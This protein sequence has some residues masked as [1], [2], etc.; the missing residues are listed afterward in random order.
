MRR[1]GHLERHRGTFLG[2][3]GLVGLVAGFRFLAHRRGYLAMV[4][5]HLP[6]GPPEFPL[7]V[8]A[9][10]YDWGPEPEPR[11]LLCGEEPVAEDSTCRLRVETSDRATY[12]YTCHARC[13]ARAAHESLRPPSLPPL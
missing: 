8:V 10:R 11:C 12:V 2:L 5:E 6:P 4:V 1:I 9:E 13:V 7:E 3:L